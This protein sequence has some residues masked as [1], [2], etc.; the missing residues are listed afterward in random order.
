LNILLVHKLTLVA[1]D[2]VTFGAIPYYRMQKPMQV[3]NRLYPEFDY[4]T[5]DSIQGATDE[6][7]QAFDLVLFCREIPEQSVERLNKLGI[8]F[9]MDIDDYWILDEDHILYEDYKEHKVAE[10]IIKALKACKFVTTTTEILASKIL[11]YNKN[12]HVIENG[13]DSEDPVW[14]PN[15]IKSDRVRFGFTQG[16][17]HFQDIDLIASDVAKSLYKKEF[18]NK[19]QVALCYKAEPG[20]ESVYIGYEKILTDHLRTLRDPKYVYDI[21]TLKKPNGEN[22]PYKQ[23]WFRDVDQFG[24]VYDEID[25]TVAPLRATEFNSC[26]SNIKMLESGFK[27][28]AIMV[29]NVAP[30]APLATK[31]NSFLFSE[32][33]F[34]YWQRYILNNPNAVED[35]KARLKEDVQK[36]ELKNLTKKRA[37][38]YR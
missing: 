29:S 18:Y 2:T 17:T 21:K 1:E 13:I 8:P 30:Y 33:D 9:G 20:Q 11:P 4:T 34:F 37:E 27:D 22:K 26:K 24:T 5:I 3:L 31:D 32:R 7:I 19:A 23:I 25:I 12:V 10:K 38:I 16:N 28:C 6:F 14:Q 15:K 35:R 36:Y